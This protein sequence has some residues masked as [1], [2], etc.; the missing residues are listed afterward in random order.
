MLRLLPDYVRVAD[1]RG[2]G[3]LEAFA[4]AIATGA[5]PARAFL[6]AADPDTSVSGTC[7]PV[8]PARASRAL[9]PWLGWLVGIDT[10]A[11][12]AA[13]VRSV[14][15]QAASSQRRGSVDAIAAAVARTLTG[16]R[17]V[18]V[19]AKPADPDITPWDYD[20]ANAYDNTRRYDGGVTDPWLIVVITKTAQTPDSVATLAAAVSEKPAG[21]QLELRTLDGSTYADLV[22]RYGTYD[23]MTA[24]GRTYDDLA[25]TFA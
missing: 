19:I 25:T 14:L 2:D 4:G 10:S 12:P 17:D 1:E 24:T 22:T 9:L 5:D 18:E 16:S 8:N 3:T 20:T 23:A 11:L 6:D 21:M 13:D 7:E 15:G